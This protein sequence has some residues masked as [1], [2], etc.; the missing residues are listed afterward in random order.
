MCLFMVQGEQTMQCS[1]K[2]QSFY[3]Y[4]CW[5]SLWAYGCFHGLLWEATHL[6]QASHFNYCKANAPSLIPWPATHKA[7]THSHSL[8]LSLS[9]HLN[10]PHTVL[11][12]GSFFFFLVISS[13][14]VMVTIKA[15]LRV[16]SRHQA[17]CTLTLLRLSGSFS[18]PHNLSTCQSTTQRIICSNSEVCLACTRCLCFHLTSVTRM[19]INI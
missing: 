9:L 5:H 10:L 17:Q 1:N 2:L 6:G 3:T 12:C 16:K 14:V 11:A 7:N 8:S 15:L 18:C 13:P 4:I 19:S